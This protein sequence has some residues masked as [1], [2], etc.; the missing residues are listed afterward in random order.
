MRGEGRRG[1]GRG[2]EGIKGTDEG[3]R[4]KEGEGVEK[5]ALYFSTEL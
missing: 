5:Y 2:E 1:K 3:K 4:R